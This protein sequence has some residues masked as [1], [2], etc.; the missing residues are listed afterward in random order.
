LPASKG[1]HR[2]VLDLR[3]PTLKGVPRVFIEGSYQGRK[4]APGAYLLRLRMGSKEATTQV[5]VM[6]HPKITATK[7]EYA[8]QQQWQKKVEDDI[9]DIHQSVLNMRKVRQQVAGINERLAKN[10]AQKT[11]YDQGQA[12]VKKLQQWED[13]LVQNK[14]QSNDDII[15]F[16]NKLSADYIFLRGEMDANIP[17]VTKGQKEQFDAMHAIWEKQKAAMQQMLANEISAFNKLYQQAG[18]P[19]VL[20][21]N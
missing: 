16:V 19:A 1:L 10:A 4:V 7:A 18:L 3:Y 9:N 12:I 20:I 11:L 13:E 17:Y 8:E 14:A 5:R 21:P 2:F 6:P 15:N